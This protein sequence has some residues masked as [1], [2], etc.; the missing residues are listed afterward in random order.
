MKDLQ[1]SFKICKNDQHQPSAQTARVAYP[2][3]HAQ[4]GVVVG[5]E[6]E[7][8]GHDVTALVPDVHVVRLC[9]RP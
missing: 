2:I 8:L 1:V 5:L 9:H 4:H 3:L 6:R 7:V